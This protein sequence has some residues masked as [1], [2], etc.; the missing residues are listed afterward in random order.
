MPV[1]LQDAVSLLNDAERRKAAHFEK[2]EA[3]DAD[4]ESARLQVQQAKSEQIA[5]DFTRLKATLAPT[6]D[7]FK[8]STKALWAAASAKL[9]DFEAVDKLWRESVKLWE[10]Y[11]AGRVE[12]ASASQQALF[13]E[14]NARIC[15]QYGETDPNRIGAYDK[16]LEM[17]ARELTVQ[18][19]YSLDPLPTL[20]DELSEFVAKGKGNPRQK[21]A[22]AAFL[23]GELYRVPSAT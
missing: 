17:L 6:A 1:N 20:Y 21:Q 11:E 4:I 10:K 23:T 2:I 7:K 13:D 19:G 15:Q 9:V 16:K 22:I 18:K 14:A 5:A 8:D 12:V 3:F